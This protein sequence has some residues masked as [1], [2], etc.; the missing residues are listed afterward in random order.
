MQLQ[1]I[2]VENIPEV[3][4]TEWKSFYRKL[5][6]CIHPDKE[7]DTGMQSILNDFDKMM[8]ILFKQEKAVQERRDWNSDY[9][10]WKE[11]HG[12]KDDFIKEEEL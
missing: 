7:E 12:Y 8:T 4:R 2:L 5:S 3:N 10:Q 11:D 9:E 6:H 1:E